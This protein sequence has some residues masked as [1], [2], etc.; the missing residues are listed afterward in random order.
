M[1]TVRL[2]RTILNFILIINIQSVL[3]LVYGAAEQCMSDLN[4][5]NYSQC[6]MCFFI[7]FLTTMQHY[8][9]KEDDISAFDSHTVCLGRSINC[10]VLSFRGIC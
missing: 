6:N 4:K 10:N 5:M 2:L 8:G 1:E 3:W 9:T 7:S